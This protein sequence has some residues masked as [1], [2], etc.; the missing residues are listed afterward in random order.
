MRRFWLIAVACLLVSTGAWAGARRELSEGAELGSAEKVVVDFE[1]GELRIEAGSSDR[2][3]VELDLRCNSGSAKCE[4]RLEDAEIVLEHRGQRF[5]VGFEGLS[6]R[7]NNKMD[8][9]A[10]VKMPAGT[11]LSVDMGIGD[12]TIEGIDSDIFVD[13]GIGEASLELTE[14]NVRAVY[15]DAG[16]GETSVWAS[17]GEVSASRPFLIGSEVEW[18]AGSGDAEIV[19]DLGI[20][21]IKVHLD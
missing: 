10:V 4:R 1:V 15:L 8:I 13:M 19:V 12:L 14:S 2:V 9:E 11:E 3:E 17:R 18:E 5:F 20:G 7:N 21:E 6:K 16:I